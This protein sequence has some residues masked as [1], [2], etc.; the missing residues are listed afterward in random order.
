MKAKK[1]F[2]FTSMSAI[3]LLAAVFG[4]AIVLIAVPRADQSAAFLQPS[5]AFKDDAVRK[6]LALV[7]GSRGVLTF[8]YGDQLKPGTDPKYVRS[9]YIHPLYGPD[10]EVLTDDSPADH[11]HHHGLFWTWPII[12]TRGVKTGT[13][14]PATPPLRQQFVRWI[15]RDIKDGAAALGV[16]SVWKLDDKEIVARE[17]AEFIVHSASAL[18]RLIDVSLVIEAV[19]GPLEFQG[20]QDAGKGLRRAVLPR[21]SGVQRGRA[22]DR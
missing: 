8:C 16:E 11:L 5:F 3:V 7:D 20:Q 17:T 10:G 14:E 6:T 4:A 2:V 9:G 18:G 22:D 1:P 13:W 15:R 19:G 21:R 12:R